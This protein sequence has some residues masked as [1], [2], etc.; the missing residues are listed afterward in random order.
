MAHLT[1]SSSKLMDMQSNL[2]EHHVND[3]ALS[4]ITAQWHYAGVVQLHEDQH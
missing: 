1:N 4:A 2:V 3:F